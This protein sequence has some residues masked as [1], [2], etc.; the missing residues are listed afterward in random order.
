MPGIR[1]RC[2]VQMFGYESVSVEEQHSRFVHEMARFQKTWHVQGAVSDATLSDDSFVANWTIKTWGPNWRVVTD[3]YYF[4]WDDIV[5]TDRSVVDWRRLPDGIAALMEFLVTGTAIKYFAV[6]WR[7]GCFFL[8][9]L[10]V[11]CGLCWL[12]I[13]LAWSALGWSGLAHPLFLAPVAALAIFIVLWRLIRTRMFIR[14]VLDD[15]CFARD[16]ARRRRPELEARLD[17][18]AGELVR[19]ARE[20]D[21]DEIVVDGT[22]LGA[23]LTLLIVDLAL[24]RD[25]QLGS[26]GKPIHLVSIGSSLLKLA[27]HPAASWLRKAVGR[28]ANA[29]AVYWVEFQAVEDFLNVYNI[30]PVVALGMP[31]TGKPIVR[32]TSVRLMV[33]DA[34]YRRLLLNFFRMHRQSR[35]GNERR[36]YYDYYMVCCGPIALADRVEN[37]DQ[38]VAAFAADGALIGRRALEMGVPA[39]ARGQGP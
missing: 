3:Y 29:P 17:R 10:V 19:L 7:Y 11:I 14:Y 15:W 22:S 33:E 28:V 30:D 20:T 12:S 2:F 35:S 32:L 26:G 6:A 18:F 39:N 9:P 13:W 27:L 37:S 16:L 21:A 36:Y 23:P 25:P 1:K 5:A 8:Y 24:A 34:T 4:R 38:A 31:A